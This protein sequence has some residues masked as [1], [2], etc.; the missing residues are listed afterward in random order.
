MILYEQ[1]CTIVGSR[2]MHENG[3]EKEMGK[4]LVENILFCAPV[5]RVRI[6]KIKLLNFQLKTCSGRFGCLV[7]VRV[8]VR[9]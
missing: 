3:E 2:T 9:V 4:K 6:I 1:F 7:T 8:L 5:S